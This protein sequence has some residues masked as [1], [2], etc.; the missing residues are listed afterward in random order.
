MPLRTT[1]FQAADACGWDVD[2]LAKRSGVSKKMLYAM[3][4]GGRN[5]GTKTIAG[6]MRAFPHLPYERL[7]VPLESTKVS[8][9]STPQTSVAA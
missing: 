3:R 2:E 1:A 9:T 5:P 7:F 8:D 4:N 6:L